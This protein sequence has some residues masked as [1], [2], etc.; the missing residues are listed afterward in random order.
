MTGKFI[1]FEGGEGAGKSTQ[2]K[3]LAN[4]FSDA[5]IASITTREPGGTDGAESIRALLVKADSCEWEKKTE[6]FLHIAARIEH[7][8]KLIF[9]ALNEEKFVICDRFSDSS[10]AYQG[11]GHG[12]GKEFVNNITKLA[13][14][15]FKPDITFILDIDSKVGISRT[16]SR[17]GFEDRYEKM[18]G[19][20]H[21]RVR[22]GFLHIAENEPDRCCLIDALGSVEAIHGQIIA[23]INKICGLSL[24][25]VKI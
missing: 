15:D 20:F 14:G 3:M 17:N 25:E 22:E 2:V 8:N 5:G 12:L 9:P 6:I 18:A 24:K 4:A 19:D 21:S 10:M 7:V 23:H 16:K 1:T 13:I 11:F